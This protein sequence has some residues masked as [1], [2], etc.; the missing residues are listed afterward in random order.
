MSYR[1]LLIGRLP[2]W[3]VALAVF[4][5]IQPGSIKAQHI[6]DHDRRRLY[7]ACRPMA[8]VVKR[9][10]NDAK[11]I[12][13]TE[14]RLWLAAVTHLRPVGIYSDSYD[15]TKTDGSVLYVSAHVVGSGFN[16]SVEYHKGGRGVVP[17]NRLGAVWRAHQVGHVL[18]GAPGALRFTGAS[19]VLAPLNSLILRFRQEYLRVNKEDCR[20]R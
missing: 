10:S 19:F 20:R 18:P 2:T 14:H 4:A 3:F 11:R 1:N 5:V 17:S 6:N 8:V 12:G 13:L 15:R 9:L 16:V 7:N